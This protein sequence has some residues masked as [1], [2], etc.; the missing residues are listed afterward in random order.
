MNEK[1]L[2]V[3]DTS[4]LLNFFERVTS[5]REKL[6][7]FLFDN[8][9]VLVPGSVIMEA[10]SSSKS[11]IT[12]TEITSRCKVLTPDYDSH[13]RNFLVELNDRIDRGETDV[14]LCAIEL[15]CSISTDDLAAIKIAKQHD[16]S[17]FGTIAILKQAYDE[18]ILSQLEI[19][20]VISEIQSK[21][22]RFKNFKGLT[23]EEYYAQYLK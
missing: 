9:E 17:N 8:Y 14:V 10:T 6:Q 1:P 16:L 13:D 7:G 15:N 2:L 12:M 20:A 3:I 19:G 4:V 23:F 18:G 5:F 11:S 22:G 21:G